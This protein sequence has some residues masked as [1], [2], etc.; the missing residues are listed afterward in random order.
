MGVSLQGGSRN[1]KQREAVG[2]PPSNKLV[3]AGAGSGENRGL[4]PLS[5]INN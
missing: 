4:V 3:L 1:C 2:A 5:L